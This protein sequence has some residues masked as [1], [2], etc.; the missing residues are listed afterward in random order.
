MLNGGVL[1]INR[2]EKGDS[3][4]IDISYEGVQKRF[5]VAV[6]KGACILDKDTRTFL[7][8]TDLSTTVGNEIYRKYINDPVTTRIPK[9]NI[10]FD[11]TS[12]AH[13]NGGFNT[14]NGLK[15]KPVKGECSKLLEL[16]L[17]MC[18]QNNIVFEWVLRWFAYPLK[19]PGAKMRT[20]IVIHGG[21]G[22]GKNLI[23]SAIEGIYGEY[24]S[25]ITQNDL[26]SDFNGWAS[27]KLFVIG[28]E[29]STRRGMYEQ[30]GPMKNMI[31]EPEW[32][33]NEKNINVR[34]EKN[35][36]NFVF[37]S[38]HLQ[39]VAPDH[40][41]RRYQV[42]W[43]PPKKD[44]DFY[45]SV[46][47]ERDNGGIAALYYYLMSLDI[48]SFN[49]FT[50]PVM[51]RAKNDLIQLSMK[52]DERFISCWLA[53]ELTVQVKPC[54]TDDLYKYYQQWC[55]REG[56]K[57]HVSLTEFGTR[58]G[59]CDCQ[60]IKL[61]NQRYRVGMREYKGTFVF[62]LDSEQP[63]GMSKVDWLTRCRKEFQDAVKDWVE[64]FGA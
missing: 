50:E 19:N 3:I 57:F 53:G 39:P 21:E 11:P 25:I 10:V 5:A 38:N 4:G 46:A 49:E 9:D 26:K 45:D 33:I 27:R 31:T 36:A 32:N 17:L 62:H 54:L 59:K 56:E 64:V 41:D 51:T 35:Y 20:A 2:G 40:D 63:D 58:I 34:K 16:L 12:T 22:V 61:K 28:N 42:L 43:T 52:S 48:G 24:S 7:S 29:V 14:F 47:R 60:L 55:K 44:K 8:S 23:L 18:E 37:T 1:D 13:E 15:I 30:S 6:G